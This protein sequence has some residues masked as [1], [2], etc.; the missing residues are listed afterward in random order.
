M[1]EATLK[2]ILEELGYSD[3]KIQKSMKEKISDNTQIRKGEKL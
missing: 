2:E 3:G 1:W